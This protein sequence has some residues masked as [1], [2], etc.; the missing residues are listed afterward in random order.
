MTEFYNVC[1]VL[2]VMAFDLYM[3]FRIDCRD[4]RIAS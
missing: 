2:A 3:V 1:E 4:Q